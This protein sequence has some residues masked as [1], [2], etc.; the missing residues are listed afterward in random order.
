MDFDP[1]GTKIASIEAEH[2]HKRNGPV[3]CCR[4]MFTIWLDQPD[5]TWGNLIELLIDSDQK[6]LAEQ[7]KDA[8]AL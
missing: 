5:A 7:V 8:L 6:D 1:K 2:A 4:E 3:I